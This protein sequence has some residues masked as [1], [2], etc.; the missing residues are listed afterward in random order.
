MRP[1]IV[2]VVVLAAS[3][4]DNGGGKAAVDATAHTFACDNATCAEGAQYC[5]RYA[6]GVAAA[7]AGCNDLPAACASA[8][9]CD[10]LMA[11]VTASCGNLATCA[12][13]GADLT[14]SCANP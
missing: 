2:L 14:L 1:V 5:F 6:N 4:G 8:P 10:C 7:V 13:Q 3:C 9:T 12:A 11:N